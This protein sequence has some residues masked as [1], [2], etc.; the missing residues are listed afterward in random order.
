MLLRCVQY[1]SDIS[2]TGVDHLLTHLSTM[3]TSVFELS[4]RTSFAMCF[5]GYVIL[6]PAM[7]ERMIF[8]M[9]TF[10]EVMLSDIGL[11]TILLVSI[12][13]GIKGRIAQHC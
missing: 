3:W 2:D 12:V 13:Q 8:V 9:A 5:H 6:I 7:A 4:S 10:V 11:G 1:Q